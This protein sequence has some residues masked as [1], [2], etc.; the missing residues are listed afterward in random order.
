MVDQGRERFL[1]TVVVPIVLGVMG[2]AL[3]LVFA[4]GGGGLARFLPSS[5]EG[6]S[7]MLEVGSCFVVDEQGRVLPERCSARNDGTV[8]AQVAEP[9]QCE[10]LGAGERIAFTVIE[11]RTFCLQDRVPQG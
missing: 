5:D 2:G 4:S 7:L 6:P 10:L 11:A 3:L 8:L 9:E 1:R